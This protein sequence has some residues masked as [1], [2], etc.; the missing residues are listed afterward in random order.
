M[1]FYVAGLFYSS[2]AFI[3]RHCS[4]LFCGLLFPPQI[5]QLK[6]IVDV[7]LLKALCHCCFSG[8]EVRTT[9]LI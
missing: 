8:V 7:L 6:K 1:R 9:I 3:A 5:Q 4:A 2:Q